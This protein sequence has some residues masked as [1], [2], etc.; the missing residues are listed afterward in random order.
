MPQRLWGGDMLRNSLL[1]VSL[2]LVAALGLA[3]W[4]ARGGGERA[5]NLPWQVDVL[6]DGASRVFGITLGKTTARALNARLRKIPQVALFVTPAGRMSLEAYYGNVSLGMFE[7]RVDVSLAASGG[8]LARLAARAVGR[9]PTAT[10]AWRLQLTESDTGKALGLPIAGITYAPKVRYEKDLVLKSFGAPTAR[11]DVGKRQ[12]YW[13]YPRR[14]LALLRAE[15][16]RAVLHY[17]TPSAFAAVRARI[18]RMAG[19]A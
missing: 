19:R 2:L 14:G 16:G 4:F 7:A 5:T 12:V 8:L 9:Q 1:L 18:E 11:I 17:V 3:S 10:G 15:D 13:L 6:P